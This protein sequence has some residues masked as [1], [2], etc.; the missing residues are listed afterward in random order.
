LRAYLCLAKENN[1]STER[2]T[3]VD[4]HMTCTYKFDHPEYGRV[5]LIEYRDMNGDIDEDELPEVLDA[6]GYAI[7]DPDLLQELCEMVD[8][9]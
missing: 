8:Y 3:L 2:L 5:T 9:L 7:E 4:G 1:M 6:N